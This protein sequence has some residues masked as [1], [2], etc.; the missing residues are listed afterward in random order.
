MKG[1]QKLNEQTKATRQQTFGF[2]LNNSHESFSINSPSNSDGEWLLGVTSLEIYNCAFMINEDN[3]SFS[4]DSPG[5]WE[6]FKTIEEMNNFFQLVKGKGRVVLA[7]QLRSSGYGT[8]FKNWAEDPSF[9]LSFS[10]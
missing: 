1:I 10:N 2:K 4:I 5:L 7:A 3:I 6:D 8:N 9:T